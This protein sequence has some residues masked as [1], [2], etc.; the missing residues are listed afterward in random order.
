[1]RLKE[2]EEKKEVQ[3]VKEVQEI[4]PERMVDKLIEDQKKLLKKL[5]GKIPTEL[6]ESLRHVSLD[7]IR[8]MNGYGDDF[9]SFNIPDEELYDDSKQLLSCLADKLGIDRVHEKPY[10]E[11]ELL[12]VNSRNLIMTYMSMLSLQVELI[13]KLGNIQRNFGTDKEYRESTIKSMNDILQIVCD[14]RENDKFKEEPRKNNKGLI[15]AYREAG[16]SQSDITEAYS[17]IERTK[18]Q[19]RGMIIETDDKGNPIIPENWTFLVH[20]SS[21]DRWDS[22]DLGKD[23]TIKENLS[24]V[25]RDD[26]KEDFLYSGRT[27]A[28]TYSGDNHPFRIHVLFYKNPNKVGPTMVQKL[29]R[30]KVRGILDCYDSQQQGRRHPIVPKGTKMT[31]LKSSDYD[32]ISESTG[33]KILWYIPEEFLEEYIEAVREERDKGSDESER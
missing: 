28:D 25:E 33:K 13:D 6:Y 30:D 14:V 9:L 32:E 2:V 21:L 19:Q 29:G 15:R 8:I 17:T 1:M 4:K 10:L 22:S 7:I 24:C 16:V 11:Q 20:G 18:Q 23:F 26:A 3:E 5:G 12:K 31:Y 27:T